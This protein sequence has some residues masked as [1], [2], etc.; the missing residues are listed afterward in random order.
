VAVSILTTNLEGKLM[1]QLQH[2]IW[3]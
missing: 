3:N 1:V 2:S